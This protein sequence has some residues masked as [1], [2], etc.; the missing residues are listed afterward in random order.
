LHSPNERLAAA[1]RGRRTVSSALITLAVLV[2]IVA[3]FASLVL[4]VSRES[5]T[6]LA[7]L[8]DTLGLKSVAELRGATLP[9]AAQ[10]TLDHVPAFFHVSREQ[11]FDGVERLV[12]FAQDEMPVMIAAG[13]RAS[14][15]AV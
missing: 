6:G 10:Q 1:L 12:G 2:V 14:L 4:F 11:V 3:P 15:S 13:G 5:M 8:R 9:D 7:Y